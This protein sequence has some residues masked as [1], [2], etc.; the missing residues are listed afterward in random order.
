MT[1]EQTLARFNICNDYLNNQTEEGWICLTDRIDILDEYEEKQTDQEIDEQY[2][3]ETK[4]FNVI[5]R[6]WDGSDVNDELVYWV[7][8]PSLDAVLSLVGN[9]PLHEAPSQMDAE[10]DKYDFKD[11]VDI[12]INSKG[13]IIAV[14]EDSDLPDDEE[15]LREY[16][17]EEVFWASPRMYTYLPTFHAIYE[18]GQASDGS[19]VNCKDLHGMKFEVVRVI[20]DNDDLVSY[21][22]GGGD[23][24]RHLCRFENGIEMECWSEEVVETVNGEKLC[25]NVGNEEER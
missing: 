9:V 22:R 23:E 4:L 13:Q 10:Y 7:K 24:D 15:S 14:R 19:D 11:G 6:G 5:L 21:Y 12:K 1:P 17:K 8:A 16:W 25:V 3:R 18:H 2:E 20:E